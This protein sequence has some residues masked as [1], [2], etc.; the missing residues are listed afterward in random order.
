[1]SPAGRG[2]RAESVPV[3]APFCEMMHEMSS[4]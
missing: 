2:E 1:M 4:L 3:N